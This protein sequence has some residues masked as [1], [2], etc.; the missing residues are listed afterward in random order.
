MKIRGI[1]SYLLRV[2]Y[3]L[4]TIDS[5][6]DILPVLDS[7]LELLLPSPGI[8]WDILVCCI[9]GEQGTDACKL[10]IELFRDESGEESGLEIDSCMFVSGIG[11]VE[12]KTIRI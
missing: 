8:D 11:V 10:V 3:R 12:P 9:V 2:L 4:E 6:F 1:V 7:V 5:V